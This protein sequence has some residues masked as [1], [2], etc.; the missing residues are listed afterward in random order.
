[1]TVAW[2]LAAVRA[3]L[4][5]LLRCS[6]FTVE[7]DVGTFEQPTEVLRIMPRITD[8]TARVLIVFSSTAAAAEAAGAAVESSELLK[9]NGRL[10]SENPPP[11]K[12]S[13]AGDALRRGAQT[14][15]RRQ[16]A[17]AGLGLK[18]AVE[19]GVE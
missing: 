8:E 11:A 9:V 1:L 4:P 18:T 14:C 15:S 3:V 16:A 13:T 6:E 5:A 17:T 2:V 12:S 7:G 19:V 10:A